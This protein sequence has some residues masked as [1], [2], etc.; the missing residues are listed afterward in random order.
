MNA[1]SMPSDHGQLLADV[2]V[3]EVSYSRPARIAGQLLA[4][5]GAD[6]VRLV[7]SAAS[8][9][10]VAEPG[11]IS[12]DRG[13]RV[14]GIEPGEIAA[15]VRQTDIL[16]VDR[17]PAELA[18]L[19]L[20][21]A[22]LNP[23]DNRFVY[24]W[25][26]PYG[27]RG[28]WAE[29]A[30]DPLLLAAAAG[31]ACQYP[32]TRPNNA[33]APVAAGA[34]QLH[35]GLAAAAALAGLHGLER[36]GYGYG[37]TVS[38]LHA[39]AAALTGMTLDTLD[40]PM[41]R[42]SRDR[43]TPYWRYYEGSDGRW[44]YLATLTP[45]LFIRALVTI[46]RTDI[47]VLPEVD[48]DFL[49]IVGKPEANRVVNAALEEHFATQ[50]STYWLELFSADGIAV[51]PAGTREEWA[52]SDI[53]AA[54]GGFV[55]DVD[56]R[57]GEVRAP[58]TALRIDGVIPVP[59]R[60]P[61]G[62]TPAVGAEPIWAGP[63]AAYPAPRGDYLAPL[64]GLKAMDAGSFVAAPLVSS[65]LAEY[66]AHVVRL[67]PPDGDTYRTYSTSFLSVNRYKRGLA[68]DL[69]NP[70]GAETMLELLR[71]ADILVENLRPAR[72]ARIGLGD[73]A[74]AQANDRLIH[75]SLSAYGRADAW[76]NAPG[77]DPVFQ[78]L[79]GMAVAQGGDGYPY[80]SGVPFVDTG[81]GVL[82]AIGVLA[83]LHRRFRRDLAAKVEISLAQSVTFLQF[84]EFTTYRGSPAPAIGRADY[85]GPG[86]T[87]R[88]FECTDGWI[89]L[90]ATRP[91]ERAALLSALDVSDAG[92]LEQALA[93]HTVAEAIT[94]ISGAG[95]DVVRALSFAS[96][97]TDPFPVANDWMYVVQDK[98]FGRSMIMRGYSDW[99]T[100]EGR[101]P[102]A[103]FA[104]G[105]DSVAVLASAG[106]PA[107]RIKDL[108]EAGVVTAPVPPV[109]A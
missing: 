102:A 96:S 77:F 47:L 18:A 88:L 57:V 29:L 32:G 62:A 67:E 75:V 21:E 65:I 78:A 20:T 94:K 40:Q 11:D 108:I 100:S 19:G 51:A 89:A 73:D 66:G 107:Q 2:R 92:R 83:S 58:N 46:D 33:V 101:R 25:V 80:D 37:A 30:E 64:A 60:L 9:R 35:G 99:T 70:Q 6:V 23:K 71:D 82:G 3:L 85:R 69:R 8:R 42:G 22:D 17:P 104:V 50:P 4:D 97:F 26:P 43:K 1:T 16:I 28:E 38:G 34:T 95:V 106:V 79:S 27:P 5:L 98:Q 74:L 12:W 109:P 59:G 53:V 48:G 44:F 7:F 52:G 39:A 72:M 54:N 41:I 63:R 91:A 87:H 61:G 36:T 55:T 103:S 84:G 93:A 68:M 105:E 15:H 76:A 86:D 10:D 81:A 13:K 24:I 56:D 90:R 45:D 49:N 31:V 14:L